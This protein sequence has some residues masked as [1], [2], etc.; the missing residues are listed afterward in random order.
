[1][2]GCRWWF[3][4]GPLAAIL[5]WGLSG[6]P[7]AVDF[8]QTL[9]GPT[10]DAPLGRDH[11]GRNVAVRLVHGTHVTLGVTA[12]VTIFNAVIGSAL[13]LAAARSNA[14]VR[15]TV[16]RVVDVLVAFPAMVVGLVVAAAT[17][18]GLTVL[19]LAAVTVGWT[20]FARLAYGLAVRLGAETW[21]E[22][23][24][25]IGAGELRV[26]T[27]HL[28]PNMARPLSAH[29]IL[30]FSNTLLNLAGL[31]FLGLG[32]QPPT[33]DWGLMVAEGLP[34]LERRPLLALAPAL[35]MVV[36]AV[37]VTGAAGRLEGRLDARAMRTG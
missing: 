24:R 29:L 16:L 9:T 35:A 5:A 19:V 12:A 17:D 31:S 6:D 21:I 15:G 10:V 36:T 13:G 8:E 4:V 26:V 18:P 25:A 7:V 2:N 1:M 3:V 20:P 28:L 11:L 34:Y 14:A 23:A 37:A 33:P 32:L 30:R 27:R 22:S